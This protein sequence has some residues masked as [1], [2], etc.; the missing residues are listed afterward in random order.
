MRFTR[1][2]GPPRASAREASDREKYRQ[3][4]NTYNY[5]ISYIL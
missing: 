2:K 1:R 5:I 4:I 3:T